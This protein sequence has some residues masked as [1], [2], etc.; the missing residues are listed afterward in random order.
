[1]NHVEFSDHTKLAKNPRRN[2][3]ILKSVEDREPMVT[4][5]CF[6]GRDNRKRSK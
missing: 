5:E 6:H 1:M 4:V 3:N 2:P